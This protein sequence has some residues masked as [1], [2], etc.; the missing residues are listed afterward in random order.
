MTNPEFRSVPN[1]QWPTWYQAWFWLSA[2]ALG[3][4]LIGGFGLFMVMGAGGS[5]DY[6]W[7]VLSFSVF[8]APAVAAVA[9]VVGVG[10][11]LVF[12]VPVYLYFRSRRIVSGWAYTFGLMAA[13]VGL[14]IV[15]LGMDIY[16]VLYIENAAT[17]KHIQDTVTFA[18]HIVIPFFTAGGF[19]GYM[20]WRFKI[21]VLSEGSVNL[22]D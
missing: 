8:A 10:F 19:A 11:A 2:F 18:G 15:I 17:I 6:P 3:G 22:T 1:P 13:A 5:P 21:R 12:G 20:F 14:P 4:G 7:N 9:L 16:D